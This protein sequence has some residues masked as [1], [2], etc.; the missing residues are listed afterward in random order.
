MG[1]SDVDLFTAL[2]TVL[3]RHVG[4][5]DSQGPTNNGCAVL[6]FAGLAT[7][8][9][10]R[11]GNFKQQ[12]VASAAWAFAKVGRSAAQLSAAFARMSQRWVGD[13]NMEDPADTAET[14]T[15]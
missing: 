11:V 5:L 3:E 8:A 6:L 14:L 13:F 1:Q 12:D 4:D 15:V 2:A 10:W 9:E 7:A